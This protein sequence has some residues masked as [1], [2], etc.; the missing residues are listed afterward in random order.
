LPAK[1]KLPWMMALP[2]AAF[3]GQGSGGL[4]FTAAGAPPKTDRP[5]RVKAKKGRLAA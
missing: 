1:V 5:G 2:S 3:P 4:S